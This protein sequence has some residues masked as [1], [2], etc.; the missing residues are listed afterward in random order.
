MTKRT[1]TEA[2]RE[3]V[4]NRVTNR[5]IEQLEQGVRPWTKPWSAGDA[6]GIAVP[7]RATGKPY[8]GVNVLI[9]WMEAMAHG[10]TA[11]F[12]MTY[13]QAGELG[14]QVRKGEKGTMVVFTST[15]TRIETDDGEAVERQ[16]R[17]LRTYHVFN[18]QQI[19]GLPA[20]FY[21]PT[22]RPEPTAALQRIERA[23]QFFSHLGA[24]IRHG[25]T[26][27]FY[28]LQPDF[29]QM[30]PF[31]SFRDG[32]SYYATLGHECVHWTR[33]PS[34][35]DR[36]FGRERWGDA[37]YAR[38]ELVA[39]LGASF[40]AADLGLYLEPRE[41]HAAYVA[42]WLTVLRNDRR[43]IFVAA[44][45]AQRAIDYLHGQRPTAHPQSAADDL[46]TQKKNA[47]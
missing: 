46:E 42:D 1:T 27:A 34:R 33:H 10:Y 19:E 35:L 43:A 4:Y 3:D 9:L 38:E 16:M 22:A 18:A 26:R 40:L 47:A 2:E 28:A 44:A 30:P 23:E 13:R 6:A 36:D 25:G 5:I 12:W 45:H 17:F 15:V 8:R 24:Y 21:T 31:E 14:G 41:D 32:E 20:P 7:L 11:R 39:E 29:V 37:G